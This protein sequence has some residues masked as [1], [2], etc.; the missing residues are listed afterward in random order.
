MKHQY[1]GDTRDLFKYDLIEALVMMHPCLE[2]VQCITMLTPDDGSNHGK[3]RRYARAGAGFN[4]QDLRKF[5]QISLEKGIRDCFHIREYFSD[6]PFSFGMVDFPFTHAGRREYFFRITRLLKNLDNTLVFIDPDTGLE[7]A[8][9]G[10]NHLLHSEVSAI[11]DEIGTHSTVMIYQHF[12]RTPRMPYINKRTD[13]FLEKIGVAPSW[14]S[15]GQVIFFFLCPDPAMQ[16]S[17]DCCLWE[18][19]R[20]YPALHHSRK[21]T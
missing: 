8:R 20:R 13:E 16:P 5:L 1:F 2:K 10:T 4:N 12:P 18:Y 9:P 6:K 17:L 11:L 15:D 21:D 7:T 14:I 3:R 19:C